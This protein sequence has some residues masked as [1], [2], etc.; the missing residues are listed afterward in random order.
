[1][2]IVQGVKTTRSFHVELY[3]ACTE[4]E[5]C[6]QYRVHKKDWESG[7]SQVVEGSFPFSPTRLQFHYFQQSGEDSSWS[8]K[9]SGSNYNPSKDNDFRPS[10]LRVEYG[11]DEEN[12]IVPNWVMEIVQPYL[13]EQESLSAMEQMLE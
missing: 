9:L 8:V 5:I 13:D 4:I 11:S 1:M 10:Q 3:L 12:T 7:T 2:T 6:T